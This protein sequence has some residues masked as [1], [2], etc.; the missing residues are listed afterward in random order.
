MNPSP[1]PSTQM[2]Y[3]DSVRRLHL[4]IMDN[5]LPT[6]RKLIRGGAGPS[7]GD[8]LGRSA[9]HWAVVFGNRDTTHTILKLIGKGKGVNLADAH[10]CTAL[11]LA[12]MEGRVDIAK[13]LL[14]RG[15]KI[16]PPDKEGMTALHYAAQTINPLMIHTLV[17]RHANRMLLDARNRLPYHVARLWGGSNDVLHRLQPDNFE[18][19]SAQ[20]EDIQGSPVGGAGGGGGGGVPSKVQDRKADA[21]EAVEGDLRLWVLSA[22]AYSSAT[23][24]SIQRDR[25]IENVKRE[26]II[27]ADA[28]RRLLGMKCSPAASRSVE[29][30]A[31]P[32]PAWHGLAVDV[33]H[34]LQSLVSGLVQCFKSAGSS[35]REHSPSMSLSTA[36]HWVP[37][38]TQ[39]LR[40]QLAEGGHR[41]QVP[42]TPAHAKLAKP[43]RARLAT[44]QRKPTPY[45]LKPVILSKASAGASSSPARRPAK[46]KASSPKSK[47]K[48]S[49]T[50]SSSSS[51]S[52]G[53]SL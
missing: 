3:D 10:G 24:M 51:S 17:R 36:H 53:W 48:L 49:R 28:S 22:K 52:S 19:M 42:V 23:A 41:S 31:Q 33:P 25:P 27:E 32:A 6:V 4:A 34:R 45:S 50:S 16:N 2:S 35:L 38:K 39:V 46:P 1:S 43:G 18:A 37:T 47:K 7:V 9:L 20:I 5:D 44:P 11:H 29:E 30:A 26:M 12:A 8:R 21:V 40:A 13:M 15:A 14:N